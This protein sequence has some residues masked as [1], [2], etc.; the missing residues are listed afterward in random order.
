MFKLRGVEASSVLVA[1]LLIWVGL[2]LV[3]VNYVLGRS[4]PHSEAPLQ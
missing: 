4:R 1:S 2:T 3:R